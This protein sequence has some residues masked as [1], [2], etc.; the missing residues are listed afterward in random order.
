[1]W[2]GKVLIMVSIFVSELLGF[3]VLTY[4]DYNYDVRYDKCHM[5]M[6]LNS[7]SDYAYWRELRP[8]NTIRQKVV[9][10]APEKKLR[11]MD[12]LI[13]SSRAGWVVIWFFSQVKEAGQ[14][15]FFFW[16]KSARCLHSGLR[17]KMIKRKIKVARPHRDQM[18][19][20]FAPSL[21]CSNIPSTSKG[22]RAK[23]L[24]GSLLLNIIFNL[25]FIIVCLVS[26][27]IVLLGI[28]LSAAS[29]WLLKTTNVSVSLFHVHLYL[30]YA[31]Y[32]LTHTHRLF[33]VFSFV[34]FSLLLSV[35]SS[36]LWLL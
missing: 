1:M 23:P 7:P 15:F 20:S 18:L 30:F 29:V 17:N 8:H 16:S 25:N 33:L 31:S 12:N 11:V 32:C 2:S 9:Y 10:N 21:G 4:S 35:F 6:L 27:R 13:P 3:E 19:W 22:L 14:V 36:L 26:F 28:S 5:I 34:F 24:D